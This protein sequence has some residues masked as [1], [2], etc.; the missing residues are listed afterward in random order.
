MSPIDNPAL[1]ADVDPRPASRPMNLWLYLGIPLGLM[2]VLTLL[3]YT[4]M[5]MVVAHWFF[6][7]VAGD[8]V[9]RHS[10][11]L[12][13]VLHT[14]AKNLVILFAVGIFIA[15]VASFK[16]AKLKPIRR[17]LGYMVLAMGVSS[18]FVTPMKRLT[19]VQCPWS[20]TEFGGQETYSEVFS[21]RPKPVGKPGQC[22]P[23]G[24]ATTGFTLFALFFVYRDTRPKRARAGLALALV[25]G[26]IFSLGRM[27]QGAHFLSH[28][29]WTAAFCWLICLGSYYWVLYKKAPAHEHPAG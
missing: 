22:W 27:L 26:A 14:D 25:L 11:F 1:P 12:E 2:L 24:H 28:N 17:Q 10:K 7:P 8:F 29:L 6:D 20:L 19:S 15:F 5:D 23:G 9:G 3:Q 21:T 13:R 16:V 18:G 4:Q